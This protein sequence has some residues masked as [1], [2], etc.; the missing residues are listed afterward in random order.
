MEL[1]DEGEAFGPRR[2][3]AHHAEHYRYPWGCKN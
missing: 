1:E 3:F 2:R